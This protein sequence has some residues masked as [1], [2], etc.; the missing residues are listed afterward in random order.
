MRYWSADFN[1]FCNACWEAVNKKNAF[2]G[3]PVCI[4]C[5]CRLPPGRPGPDVLPVNFAIVPCGIHL[6]SSGN[7]YNTCRP[8]GNKG[9]FLV[10]KMVF[11]VNTIRSLK[12][13]TQIFV[14][15]HNPGGYF[16]RGVCLS[17]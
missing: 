16:L 4:V 5:P 15:E 8:S 1:G 7:P 6:N 9:L 10:R 14:K 3:K 12:K 17:S 2:A 11:I 13:N